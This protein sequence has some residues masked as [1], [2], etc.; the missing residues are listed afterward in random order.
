[1][2][3]VWSSI[4]KKGKTIRHCTAAEQIF[5]E[6][7]FRV[8][9]VWPKKTKIA[10]KQYYLQIVIVILKI[11]CVDDLIQQQGQIQLENSR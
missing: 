5:T 3:V 10:G 8:S 11:I 2:K 1:M 9:D 6:N 4:V 7:R